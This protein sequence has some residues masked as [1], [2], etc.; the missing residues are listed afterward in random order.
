MGI[1]GCGIMVAGLVAGTLFA[2][3]WLS[4]G[5]IAAGLLLVAAASW[6]QHKKNKLLRHGKLPI[7]LPRFRRCRTSNKNTCIFP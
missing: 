4:I 5:V 2:G 6:K 3:V 1:I 7:L